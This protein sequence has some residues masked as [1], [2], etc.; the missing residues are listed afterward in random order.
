MKQKGRND[1]AERKALVSGR[2]GLDGGLLVIE[3]PVRSLYGHMHAQVKPLL[4]HQ[5]V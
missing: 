4:G 2:E 3:F 5:I 1:G